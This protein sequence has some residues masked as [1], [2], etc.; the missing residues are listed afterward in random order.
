MHKRFVRYLCKG[1]H[2]GWTHDT[3]VCPRCKGTAQ[4]VAI[5]EDK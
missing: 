3:K 2:K 1:C 4:V 5:W